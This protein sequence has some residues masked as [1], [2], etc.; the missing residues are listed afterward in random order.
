MLNLAQPTHGGSPSTPASAITQQEATMNVQRAGAY[1]PSPVHSMKKIICLVVLLMGVL[2]GCDLLEEEPRN[3]IDPDRFYSSET[4]GVAAIAGIYSHLL[5]N[6]TFGIQMDIYFGIST[7]LLTPTRTLSAGQQFMGYR[8]DAGTERFRVIW[9]ELY[10]AV[11][12][13]NLTIREI[14]NADFDEEARSE[15]V[16]EAT[17]LRAF[18]YYYLTVIYGDVP[19]FTEPITGDN[20]AELGQQGKTP[21]AEVRRQI[22]SDCEFA[23]TRLP[24]RQGAFRARATRWAAKTLKLKTY[25]WL[26][27][28]ANAVTTAQDIVQNSH[29]VLLPNFADVHDPNNE[30]NDEIIFGID[31]LFDEVAVNRHSRFTPRAQDE[32]DIPAGK[33]PFPFDGFGFFTMYK[34]VANTFAAHDLRR[35]RTVFDGVFNETDSLPS[36]FAYLPKMMR[37]DDARGNSGLN[38][39]FYRL[40][41]VLL[42]LAEAENAANGPTA[43]AF[44]AINQVRARAGL[45]PLA[46][47]SQGELQA[48]IEQERIWELIGEG[49]HRKIDL[50]RWGKLGEALQN[51]LAAEQ[52]A[53]N[54]N[55]S[56]LRNAQLNVDNFQ[57]FMS[58]GPIPAAE[59]LLNPNLTQNPGY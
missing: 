8:W 10:E 52:A 13:A 26:E 45:E 41:D 43:V 3:L 31:W 30:L 34:S 1:R 54:T 55:P 4:D 57:D 21:V 50:L 22:I 20:F 58:L 24:E 32:R 39:N 18:I 42:N 28:Y 53:P 48:A 25:L 5:N 51:R 23:E 46:G 12:D 7:D 35:P 49:N 15:I 11:N 40:A 6:N 19:L 17:F 14:E 38:Y 56:L 2:P 9:T 29:H 37:P 27:E 59:I 47:L 33:R 16:A 36:N 44:D